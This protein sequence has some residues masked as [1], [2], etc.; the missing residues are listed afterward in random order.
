MRRRGQE[1][2]VGILVAAGVCWFVLTRLTSDGVDVEDGARHADSRRES[3]ELSPE[4]PG[5]RR[6]RGRFR[7]TTKSGI[8]AGLGRP[9]R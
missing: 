7:Q 8:D 4:N 5:G 1:Q 3:R 9:Q 2:L 6:D